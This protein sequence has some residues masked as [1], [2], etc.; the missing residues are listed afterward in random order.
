M[1]IAQQLR[2]LSPVYWF[3]VF[4]IIS[5]FL[6][7]I[8]LVSKL[9]LHSRKVHLRQPTQ[10]IK[11]LSFPSVAVEQAKT[12]GLNPP[13]VVTIHPIFANDSYEKLQAAGVLKIVTCNSIT[14]PSNG[15]DLTPLI[16]SALSP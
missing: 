2:D 4:A 6:I 10:T 11:R 14:H 3:I 5:I 12:L 9:V 7:A 13:V 15:I 8:Y 16:A 1:D